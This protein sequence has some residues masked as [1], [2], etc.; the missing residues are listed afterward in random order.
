MPETLLIFLSDKVD[1]TAKRMKVPQYPIDKKR[2]ILDLMFEEE[3]LDIASM[4]E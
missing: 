2:P 3:R 1:R 4:T